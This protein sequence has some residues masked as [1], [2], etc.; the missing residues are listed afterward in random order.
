MITRFPPIEPYD[1]GMLPVGD[2]HE[3]HW[4]VSGNPS[5]KPAVFLH[6][7]PGTGSSAGAHRNTDPTVYRMV[8]LD[9]RG[10]G[11]SRPSAG[12]D[13]VDLSTQTTA[14]L[15]ADLEALRVHLGIER[16]LVIGV[17]WGSTLALAYAQQHPDRVSELVL[18]AVT[19]TTRA[20]VEW[21]TRSMG[22]I[23]PEA[24]ERFVTELPEGDR[25]GDLAGAYSRR[26]AHPDRAVRESAARA[27]CDWEDVHVSLAPGAGPDPRFDDAEFRLLFARLVTHYWSHGAFL[28]EGQ[29]LREAHRLAGIPG[30]L[31]HGRHDISGPL[32]VAWHLHR[33][34]TGSELHVIED[35]GHGGPGFAETLVGALARLAG[36]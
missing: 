18:A 24:W 8:V 1:T 16:W 33:A 11:R 9:Q 20:E 35:A 17:S 14:H 21:I 7:G 23:F 34:W 10:S 4:E 13:D 15:I 28:R 19:T 3:I 30:V 12:A 29:L 25:D 26:L 22:R 6:G 5:G 36:R 32:D 31:I 27:W 2:G